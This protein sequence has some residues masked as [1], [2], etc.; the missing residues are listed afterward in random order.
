VLKRGE[1]HI[2]RELADLDDVMVK[3]DLIL[4]RLPELRGGERK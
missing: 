2:D 3:L 4:D 1:S